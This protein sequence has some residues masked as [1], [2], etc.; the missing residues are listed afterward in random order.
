MTT[1]HR[2]FRFGVA[3]G[4]R[5][6]ETLLNWRDLARKAEDLGYSTV[7]LPDHPPV[8]ASP[9]A[10]MMAAADATTTLRVGTYVFDNMLRNPAVLA[11]D[12]ATID[13]LSNGRVEIGLG[14]GNPFEGEFEALGLTFDKPGV[15]VGKLEEAIQVFKGFFS[16]EAF[17]FSGRYYSAQNLIGFP[18]PVQRPHPPIHLAAGQERMLTLAARHADIITIQPSYRV[19]DLRQAITVEAM[20]SQVARLRELAG[21]RFSA[22]ELSTQIRNLTITDGSSQPTEEPQRTWGFGSATGTIEEICEQIYA[23][24]ERFGFSYITVMAD[25]LDTFAPIVERLAGK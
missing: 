10:A 25:K 9:I 15:R 23:N 16:Q 13:V 20:E 8:L 5:G 22:I 24:R 4:L 12:I 2:A 19:T 17:N 11:S 7:L 14:A 1:P 18:A 21:E 3:V 6:D